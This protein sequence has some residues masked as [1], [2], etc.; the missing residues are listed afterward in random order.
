MVDCRKCKHHKIEN[1]KV[2]C[3]VNPDFPL[4]EIEE[5]DVC[6]D[7]ECFMYAEKSPVIGLIENLEKSMNWTLGD[8]RLARTINKSELIAR[9]TTWKEALE[10]IK[11]NSE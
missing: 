11:E 8:I 4:D 7:L 6:G 10:L 1:D 3:C 2:L 9:I 5:K